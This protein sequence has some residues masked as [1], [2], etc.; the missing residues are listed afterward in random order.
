MD[1]G[2][3]S[4][5]RI[6]AGIERAR[7]CDESCRNSARSYYFVGVIRRGWALI[8]DRSTLRVLSLALIGDE[9]D[10]HTLQ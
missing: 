8:V 2:E 3:Q 1:R 6:S 10:R 4:C 9:S 5:A 7:P